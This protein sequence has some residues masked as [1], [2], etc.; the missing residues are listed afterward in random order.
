MASSQLESRLS[1]LGWPGFTWACIDTGIHTSVGLPTTSPVKPG[2]PMPT[3]LKDD[4]FSRTLWPRIRR[5]RPKRRSQKSSLMTM[6]GLPPGTR[7]SSLER[8]RPSLGDTPSTS[9]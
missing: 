1:S 7:S 8:A 5:S 3:M 4:P 6:A 9:K 2:G